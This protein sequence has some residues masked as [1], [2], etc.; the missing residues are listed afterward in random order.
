MSLQEIEQQ[1]KNDPALDNMRKP[2]IFYVPGV[3][4]KSQPDIMFIGEAPGPMENA[5]RRPFVGKAGVFFLDLLKTAGIN[6][7]KCYVTN[8]VKYMPTDDGRNFR[9]PEDFEVDAFRS[10]LYEEIEL[11]NPEIVVALGNVPMIALAPGVS[12]ISKY[13]GQVLRT[14]ELEFFAMYHPSYLNYNPGARA[15][16][17]ADMKALSDLFED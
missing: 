4:K 10:Y 2:G 8:A 1:I 6:P 16:L 12:G 9:K 15:M 13:H 14:N 17:E 11:V 7:K 5:S 3:G